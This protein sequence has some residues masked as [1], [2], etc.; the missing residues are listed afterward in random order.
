MN[1]NRIY[2]LKTLCALTI[3]AALFGIYVLA[4][5]QSLTGSALADR[6]GKK[7]N[8]CLAKL[9][10][11]C[12]SVSGTVLNVIGQIVA[13]Q[14]ADSP[15]TIS[16]VY[17]NGDIPTGLVAGKTVIMNGEFKNGLCVTDNITIT[18]G[19]PRAVPETSPQPLGLVDRMIFFITYWLL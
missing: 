6:D 19:T 14:R 13:V 7:Q 5:V 8:E 16:L 9:D 2:M 1:S 11:P 3:V 18:E 10:T 4:K 12:R 15:F 17:I